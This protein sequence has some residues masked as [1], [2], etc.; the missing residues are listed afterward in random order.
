MGIF[1]CMGAA[2]LARLACAHLPLQLCFSGCPLHGSQLSMESSAAF[3]QLSLPDLLVR[4]FR[5]SYASQVAHST[6]RSSAWNLPLHFRSSACQSC[7]CASSVAAMLLRLPTARLAAQHG[8]FRCISAAQLASLAFAHL[9]L[10]LC[11]S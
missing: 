5:C 6:A 1:R 8:I 4:I 9:P 7:F 2:Q 10:Q 11:F 3:P